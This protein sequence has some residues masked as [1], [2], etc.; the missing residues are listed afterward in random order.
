MRFGL[1]SPT[2][3]STTCRCRWATRLVPIV[4]RFVVLAAGVG[5]A[6]LLTKLSSRFS[7]QARRKSTKELVDGC[8]AVRAQYEL[9]VRG[10][11]AGDQRSVRDLVHRD[12]TRSPD[13]GEPRTWVVSPPVDDSL[14]HARPGQPPL[15]A[16]DRLGRWWP[17]LVDQLFAA[18][19]ALEKQAARPA[20]GRST[21][22]RRTQHPVAGRRR[23][24]DGGPAGPGQAGEVRSRGLPGRVAVAPGLRPVRGRLGGRAHRR[25][26]G[27]ARSTSPTASQPAD[28]GQ[29]APALAAR[30]DRPDFDWQDWDDLPPGL[31]HQAH[32]SLS[33]RQRHPD[34][35]GQCR[36]GS[37]REGGSGQVGVAQRD[38]P[39]AAEAGL[40][41]A[42]HRR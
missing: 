2:T 14:H 5:N 9:C 4:A 21:W 28:L 35:V 13:S 22:P 37:A 31:G 36:P 18:S 19:P 17:A 29:S 7:D 38:Q 24:L 33:G 26:A 25:G 23:H 3:P 32:L 41:A 6:D 15:R 30:W 16:A 12:L 42:V 1:V 20:S 8:Q 11:P 40:V 27:P 10:R 34:S 39:L